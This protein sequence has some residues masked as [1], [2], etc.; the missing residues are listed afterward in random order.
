MIFGSVGVDDLIEVA[1]ET[2]HIEAPAPGHS[3]SWAVTVSNVSDHTLPL[4][5]EVSGSESELLS[6]DNP[7]ELELNDSDGDTIV[8]RQ[9]LRLTENNLFELP[10]L[11]PRETTTFHGV[12]SLPREAGNEYQGLS[13]EISISITTQDKVH[14]DPEPGTPTTS[15]EVPNGNLSQTG[16]DAIKMLGMSVLAIIFGL[17]FLVM[18]SKKKRVQNH[19]N[20]SN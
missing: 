12:V 7:L 5:I 14:S 15:S 9:P 1:P 16:V 3:S 6:G 18:H 19:E 2:V 13:A 17:L 11:S 4:W 10:P 20:W 8:S